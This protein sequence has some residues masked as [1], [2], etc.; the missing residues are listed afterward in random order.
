MVATPTVCSSKPPA[1]RW[2]PSGAAGSDRNEARRASSA[3][4][5]STVALRPGWAISPARNSR[6]PSSSSTSRRSAGASAAGSASGT[7]SS[8][9]TSSWRRARDRST[10]ART[11]P[12]T[13]LARDRVDRL[14]HP[15]LRQLGDCAH[16]ASVTF[17]ADVRSFRAMRYDEAKAGAL[18]S[19]VAPPFDVI[20]PEAR[21]AYL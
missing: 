5:R 2:W 8:A 3:R 20:S 15:L 7:G 10:R 21:A 13:L 17:V 1:Y 14:D 18:E 11:R 9:R 19:L 4:K 16:V 6:K 12:E